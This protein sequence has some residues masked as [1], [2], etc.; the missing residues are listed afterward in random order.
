MNRR[1]LLT[2]VALAILGLAPIA[3]LAFTKSGFDRAAFDAAQAAGGPIVLHVAATWC[4][5]CAAQK[6]VLDKLEKDHAFKAFTVFTIDFD[7]EKDVMRSFGAQSRSTLIAFKGKTEVGR[8]VGSAKE[9]SIKA[10][11]EKA[12]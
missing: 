4:E 2:V 7:K 10:L 11:L 1:N 12:L 6:A 5:T 3:A 9:A 8:L